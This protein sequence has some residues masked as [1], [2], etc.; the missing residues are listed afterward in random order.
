MIVYVWKKRRV[1][2]LMVFI[3]FALFCWKLYITIP[4]LQP[5]RTD[6]GDLSQIEKNDFSSLDSHIKKKE[7]NYGG[8]SKNIVIG[9]P[10]VEG[11]EVDLN[12]KRKD[13]GGK[14]DTKEIVED[15]LTFEAG[16]VFKPG[17]VGNFEPPKSERRTGLGEG[18]IP[19][20]LNPADENKYVKAKR[21]FGFN[22]VISDQIS[23]DRTVKDI[24]D[25]ECKYWH[26]PTDLPTASVVLVFINEG[27][28]TLMRTVHSVFN[29]S[30]SH[31]LAEIVMVDDFSDKDHLKSKLEEYIK[32]DRFEGKIK[33]V[34]NAKREGLI[35]ARTI[36]AINA[37]RGEVVVFLDAHCE[38]SPN[39][40]PPLLSRIKQNRK[41]VVCPLVDAVDAD[42][43]GYAPQAD[44][45]A[46]GVFNWD[47]FYK[48][49]P[50]PPKEANRRERNS[51]PYRSPVMAGG[52]FAL[53][54]SFFFDIGGYDNGLDIWGGEQYE[55]SFKI[56]MCGG[57]LEFVPCSRVGH[58]YRRGGIPYSYPQ[59]DDGIS[60]VNK[61]YLRVAEVWMD[62]YKEY[63][64]RMKPELRGKPYGDITEQVQFR[65]EHCPH[66]FKW[67]M[68]EVAYDIT[69]RFPLI[70]KNIGWGEVRGVGSSKCV[71]SMGRSPSGKVALYG[72][73]GYGGSQ[74]LRLNEGG[75]F[76][77]NEECLYTDGSTVK[78]ERCVPRKQYGWNFNENDS[79]ITVQDGMCLDRTETELFVSPCLPDKDT[80]K[81][82]FN[83]LS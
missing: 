80:Q 78:L 62:E 53:S 46:R 18:A 2:R 43:F 71:D 26:Y 52:L 61:N 68:D 50:I 25:P 64:Y 69:E 77:V 9:L 28:S 76:R 37:E 13:I 34:R 65:Q 23:L 33:L 59:S 6:S 54:R 8:I 32:Q 40:L 79:K 24:R 73:H 14:K 57:I 81:W 60:I 20:Q 11:I 30:P 72:C 48:R 58:I 22:M 51:E 29:T 16:A 82:Q 17:I 12:S 70:S 56:W 38:C 4:N 15:T 19:V 47:F 42:N 27:W 31:L 44:G 41:A 66:D 39:W 21:E 5:D 45:M 36:G 7:Q 75:E 74:L 10:K 3:M 67:F 49:I 55:I 35:R 83:E 1:L 63:F